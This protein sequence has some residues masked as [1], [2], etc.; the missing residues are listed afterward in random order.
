MSHQIENKEIFPQTKSAHSRPPRLDAIANFYVSQIRFYRSE[1]QPIY[2]RSPKQSLEFM[3]HFR[4]IQYYYYYYVQA[5]REN[6]EHSL[7][8]IGFFGT[9]SVHHV[10]CA[11]HTSNFR[12][13]IN[14]LP[15]HPLCVFEKSIFSSNWRMRCTMMRDFMYVL[16]Y[17][18]NAFIS[19]LVKATWL[20]YSYYYDFSCI[21]FWPKIGRSRILGYKIIHFF[22]FHRM[23]ASDY[24]Y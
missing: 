18:L 9:H 21:C 2:A 6:R 20:S 23:R 19:P 1:N 4:H 5:Y 7:I 3:V 8:F 11:R 22:M 17:V 14:A 13:W 24:Y 15:Y 10:R 16:V 12:G